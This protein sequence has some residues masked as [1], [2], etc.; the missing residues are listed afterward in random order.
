VVNRV[1]CPACGQKVPCPA[2]QKIPP[3]HMAKRGHGGPLCYGRGRSRK[4]NSQGPQKASEKRESPRTR[5]AKRTKKKSSPSSGECSICHQK[6]RLR[7]DGR[8]VAHGYDGNGFKCGGS[9]RSPVGGRPEGSTTRQVPGA[10]V[11]G[12]GLPTLGR[13]R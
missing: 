10:H 8:V 4:G 13:R 9:G 11:I 6:V 1:L 2:G 7:R 3:V 12:G 5:G